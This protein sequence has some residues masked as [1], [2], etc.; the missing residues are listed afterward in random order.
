VGFP[1]GAESGI[2]ML[3]T[4][5]TANV[6]LIAVDFP[7]AR[8][9]SIELRDARSQISEFNR[10]FD[11]TSRGRLSFRWQFPEKWFRMSKPVTDY[12][13]V[14][15]DMT[16]FR[17][18]ATEMIAISDPDVDYTNSDF[19]FVLFPRSIKLGSPDVGHANN[20][21]PSDEGPIRNLFGGAEYF[22]ERGFELWSF[23]V[24]E[25]AHPMGLAG[26]TPRSQVS[27]MDDQNGKS[28]VLNVWDAFLAGWLEADELYCMP[29]GM[30]RL[31]I[32][33]LPLER[34]VRGP[35]GV[36]V[37]ITETNGLVIEAHRAEGWGKRM[38]KGVKGLSVYWIDTTKDTDRYAGSSGYIDSDLG[39][40]WADNVVPVGTK[41][42][43]DLLVVG[44]VVS[45][46]GVTVRYVGTGAAES[47]I[48]T[49]D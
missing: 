6:Q 43:L 22:Y 24:H 28:V 45:Y 20:A 32:S 4:S 46:H 19:V 15:G 12:R 29:A 7:D 2:S 1:R 16:R 26:H 3:P 5:G 39:D 27:I 21:I 18:I 40:R 17:E 36:V 34:N 38:G 25:W 8:G 30:K 23:W 35:R 48:I 31:G 14:K 33:L 37:P 13:Y 9:T 42:N 41:R 49:R 11:S 44:D 47:V 10:W